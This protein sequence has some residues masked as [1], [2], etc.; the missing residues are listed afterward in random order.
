MSAQSISYCHQKASDAHGAG[1]LIGAQFS[2]AAAKKLVDYIERALDEL[3]HCGGDMWDLLVE[4]GIERGDWQAAIPVFERINRAYA[5]AARFSPPTPETPRPLPK[6]G[7]CA[8]ELIRQRPWTTAGPPPRQHRDDYL[9][10]A[11]AALCR[12]GFLVSGGRP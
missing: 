12:A 5:V 6:A 9:H 8:R 4:F 11:R 7:P 1:L 2:P 10:R 3:D